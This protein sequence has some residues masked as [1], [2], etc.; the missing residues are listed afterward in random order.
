[1][2]KKLP[3]VSPTSN[4]L[5]SKLYSQWLD[6]QDSDKAQATLHTEYHAV[7]KMDMP[8]NIKWWK[9]LISLILHNVYINNNV[10]D[11]YKGSK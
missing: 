1:M 9:V 11:A 4:T 5:T 7:E 10:L 6:G 2:Y 8:L 3:V